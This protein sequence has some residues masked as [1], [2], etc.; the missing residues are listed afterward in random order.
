M[1]GYPIHIR[2][3]EHRA[4]LLRDCKYFLFKGL[5]QKLIP[6]NISYNNARLRD[7]ITIRLEDIRQPGLSVAT[8]TSSPEKFDSG[9][10]AAGWVNYRRPF[11]DDKP[12]ELLIEIG[13]DCTRLNI[14]TMRA[15]FFGDAKRRMA[16]LYEVV[17]SKLELPD[18]PSTG[19]PSASVETTSHSMS[20]DKATL[21]GEQVKFEFDNPGVTL[22]GVPWHQDPAAIFVE[23]SEDESDET[24]KELQ[25]Q[26]KRRRIETQL[27]TV[28]SISS[29]V[30]SAEK[31][32]WTVKTGQ[33]RLRVQNAN[34][35]E[36]KVE[37]VLVAVKIDAIASELARNEQRSFL[38]S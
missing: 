15:E 24:A 29:D 10:A 20:V 27:K 2:D 17:A 11:V 19:L 22:D 30:R 9:K 37:C 36:G 3:E 1:R 32:F 33:W 5:E 34:D 14:Q 4:G 28:L 8:E 6:H 26:R 18:T 35:G 21:I 16:R 23:E 31:R 13:N 25:P 7:E 38:G 12:Y